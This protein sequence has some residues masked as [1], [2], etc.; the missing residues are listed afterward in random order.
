[1]RERR[2]NEM[3]INSPLG[4]WDQDAR[5]EKALGDAERR[6]TL[7]AGRGAVEGYRIGEPGRSAIARLGWQEASISRAAN[8]VRSVLESLHVK[9]REPRQA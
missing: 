9:E 7:E 2:R 4:K 3:W 8:A 1:M 6:R 5:V